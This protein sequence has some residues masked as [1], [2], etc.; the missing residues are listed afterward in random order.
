MYPWEYGDSLSFKGIFKTMHLNLKFL[1]ILFITSEHV[2]SPR[3]SST[4]FKGFSGS[5]VLF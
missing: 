4:V 3:V 1:T 2:K 5:F